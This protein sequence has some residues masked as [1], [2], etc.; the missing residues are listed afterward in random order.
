MQ[1]VLR[2]TEVLKKSQSALAE[3]ERQRSWWQVVADGV[4]CMASPFAALIL[5]MHVP[6]WLPDGQANL[7]QLQAAPISPSKHTH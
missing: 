4:K 7:C 3:N 2:E 1:L 5:G 6:D